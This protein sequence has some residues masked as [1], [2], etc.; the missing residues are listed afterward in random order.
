MN[1]SILHWALIKQQGTIRALMDGSIGVG[2][3]IGKILGYLYKL[4]F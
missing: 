4:M 2:Y 3:T 1:T